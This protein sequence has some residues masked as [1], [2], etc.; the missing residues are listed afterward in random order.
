MPITRR[1]FELGID[2][3]I[4]EWMK[5]IHSFL[6][7]RKDEAFTEKELRQHFSPT[8]LERLSD[9]QKRLVQ[10]QRERKIEVDAFGFLPDEREA[11]ELALEK[12]E[13]Q[14]AVEE[15]KI[16]DIYYYSYREEL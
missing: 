1:Q 12:L 2:S 16:R 15:R 5:K 10:S 14:R 13:E 4:E 3:K 11:F 8:L 6:S 7:E 9:P